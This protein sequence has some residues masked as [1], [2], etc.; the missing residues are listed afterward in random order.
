MGAGQKNQKGI[1]IYILFAL[2]NVYNYRHCKGVMKNIISEQAKRIIGELASIQQMERGKLT[3]EYRTRPASDGDGQITLGPY[4]KL[5]AREDGKN[6]SRRIPVDEVPT[7][8]QDI[9]NYKQFKHL[10]A[11][12]ENTIINNTRERRASESESKKN[13]TKK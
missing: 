6:R 2:Y 5:Q 11:D 13:S 4:Y 3:S 7:L 12:L 10:V 9:A 8:E 1:V